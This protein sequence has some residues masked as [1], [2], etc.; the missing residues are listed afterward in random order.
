MHIFVVYASVTGVTD[1]D[2]VRDHSTMTVIKLCFALAHRTRAKRGAVAVCDRSLRMT[3]Q[4]YSGDMLVGHDRC[5]PKIAP[6]AMST[7]EHPVQNYQQPLGCITSAGD[8]RAKLNPGIRIGLAGIAT[9]L[10]ASLDHADA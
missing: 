5:E 8:N 9:P 4:Q 3:T 1:T 6:N 2:T 7:H 10:T